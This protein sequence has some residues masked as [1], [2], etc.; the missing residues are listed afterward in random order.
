MCCIK[1]NQNARNRKI[2]L[3]K[4]KNIVATL[5]VVIILTLGGVFAVNMASKGHSPFKKQEL[6]TEKSETKQQEIT[7]KNRT[8]VENILETKPVI[9]SKDYNVMMPIINN[10]DTNDTKKQLDLLETS[11]I[12]YSLYG[13]PGLG[14]YD[15]FGHHSLYEGQY[16]TSF[17][18]KLAKGDIVKIIEKKD[19]KYVVYSYEISY[20][21]TVESKDTSSVY[22]ES[23]KPILTIGTCAEPYKTDKR[24]IWQGDLVNSEEFNTFSELNQVTF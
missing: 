23:E 4:K 17:V 2:I 16:F 8:D 15:V 12:S 3:K 11:A 6:L 20:N 18:D 21:F 9:F 22:Y 10:V 1:R 7:K 14:N 24:I 13:K 5:I 19:D